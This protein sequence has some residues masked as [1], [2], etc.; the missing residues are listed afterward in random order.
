MKKD[1][2]IIA[3][4]AREDLMEIWLYIASDSI[5]SADKFIDFLYE[6]C[7]NLC[8]SPEVGRKRDE[9]FPSL[10]CLPVKR[11]LIFYRIK[12]NAIEIIRILSAYRDIESIF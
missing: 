4:Q 10:R 12:Q 11:Y 3:D 7:A 5:S 1:Q 9:L 8:S 2:L 6:K